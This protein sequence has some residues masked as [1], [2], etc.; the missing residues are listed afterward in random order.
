M[1][2]GG[3]G[4]RLKPPVLKTGVHFVDREFESRP[5]RHR[6]YKCLVEAGGS[7]TCFAGGNEIMSKYPPGVWEDYAGTLHF[8]IGALRDET[9]RGYEVSKGQYVKVEE[10]SSYYLAPDK[11]A[12]KP[13]RLLADTMAKTGRR[14]T[15]GRHGIKWRGASAEAAKVDHSIERRWTPEKFRC[16]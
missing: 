6:S 12:N 1:L 7:L 9:V 3:V 5:L 2:I 16:R 15:N 14:V 13:Y 10:R 8:D 11:G 4:E